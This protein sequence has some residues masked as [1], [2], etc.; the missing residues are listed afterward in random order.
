MVNPMAVGQG[1][2]LQVY[3]LEKAWALGERRARRAWAFFR[4]R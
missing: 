4:T 3:D 1:N 2:G